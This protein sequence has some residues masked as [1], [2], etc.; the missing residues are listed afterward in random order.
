MDAHLFD[1]LSSPVK[2]YGASPMSPTY[3]ELLLFSILVALKQ[4]VQADVVLQNIHNTRWATNKSN[5][6]N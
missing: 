5:S 1:S 3:W 6:S 2:R 4:A